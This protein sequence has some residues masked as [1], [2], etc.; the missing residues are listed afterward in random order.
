MAT[1]SSFSKNSMTIS[2]NKT[3]ETVVSY[4]AKDGSKIVVKESPGHLSV[5]KLK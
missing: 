4:E 2:P 5:E 1:A 3:K